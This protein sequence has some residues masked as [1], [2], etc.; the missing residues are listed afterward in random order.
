MLVAALL[1]G[2]ALLPDDKI[3]VWQ[4]KGEPWNEVMFVDFVLEK[5]QVI[6]NWMVGRLRSKANTL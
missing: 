1:Q 4:H 5:L 6:K 2:S 3:K